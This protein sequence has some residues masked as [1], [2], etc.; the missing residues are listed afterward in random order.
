MYV[1][2]NNLPFQQQKEQVLERANYL[3]KEATKHSGDGER[4]FG[5]SR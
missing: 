1:E 3:A 5:C 4:S 2:A